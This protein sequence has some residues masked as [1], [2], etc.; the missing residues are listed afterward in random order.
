MITELFVN[1]QN[2]EIAGTFFSSQDSKK[3]V[4]FA[5]GLGQNRNE[6]DYFY[7]EMC[8]KFLDNLVDSFIFDYSGIG[9]STGKFEDVSLY[10]MEKDLTLVINYLLAKYEDKYDDIYF[11]GHGIGCAIINKALKRFTNCKFK[12]IY[13]ICPYFYYKEMEKISCSE[14]EEFLYFTEFLGNISFED[15]HDTDNPMVFYIMSLGAEIENLLGYRI[16]N[17]SFYEILK[18]NE[19]IIE[20][21]VEQKI[22]LGNTDLRLQNENELESFSQ[23]SNFE[24]IKLKFSSN[25]TKAIERDRL[26]EIILKSINDD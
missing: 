26:Y 8:K 11:V 5:C 7:P 15:Y 9:E 22:F 23:L 4:I 3:I 24:V 18:S 2:K 17:K 14:N 1:S 10:T 16:N 20:S 21:T 12:R 6:T 25:F 19:N 13:S